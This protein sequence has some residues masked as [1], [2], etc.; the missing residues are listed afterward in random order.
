MDI[1]GFLTADCE[2]IYREKGKTH[3]DM[4]GEGKLSAIR[5][6]NNM[7]NAGMLRIGYIGSMLIVDGARVSEEQYYYL[8]R[9]VGNHSW[10]ATIYIENYVVDKEY[11]RQDF[12]STQ[13]FINETRSDFESVG[14][15][16]R[17]DFTPL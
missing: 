3:G 17:N 13:E 5:N 12:L 11:S 16:E 15:A 14:S 8:R 2:Y 1:S 10:I 4:F 9:M 7:C 6:Y